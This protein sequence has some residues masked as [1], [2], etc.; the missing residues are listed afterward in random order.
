MGFPDIEKTLAKNLTGLLEPGPDVT[1]ASIAAY[2]YGV[3]YVDGKTRF[4][5]VNRIG[6]G[7]DG[8]TDT[9]NVAIDVFAP[10]RSEAYAVAEQI[11]EIL[12]RVRKIGGVVIDGV[13]TKSGPIQAPWDNE[14]LWRFLALYQVSTRR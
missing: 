13:E 7:S 12:T 8:I 1:A 4:V 3:T 5:R 9:P 14:N 2:D 10:A 6:G 11:R